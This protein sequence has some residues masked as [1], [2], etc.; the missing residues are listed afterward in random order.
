MQ[1]IMIKSKKKRCAGCDTDQFIYKNIGR[2]KYCK[3]CT[4]KL[5]KP[6]P[7]SPYSKKQQKK[8]QKYLIDIVEY[9]EKNSCCIAKICPECTGCNIEYITVSHTKGRIGDLLLDQSHWQSI[10]SFCH[11][12]VSTHPKEAK[13]LGLEFSR[14]N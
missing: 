3:S 8:N 7:I 12:W 13:A 1:Q 9:K 10:C 11:T 14:L 4:F 6:K 2:E 5:E